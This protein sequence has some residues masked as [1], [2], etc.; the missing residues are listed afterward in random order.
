MVRKIRNVMPA[1]TPGSTP[2]RGRVFFAITLSFPFLILVLL[3]AVLRLVQYGGDLSLVVAKNVRGKEMYTINRAVARRYFIEGK[4]TVPEP[5]GGAFSIKKGD[6][7]KRIFCLGESTMAGFPYEFNATP[8]SFLSDYLHA[9]LPSYNFE[10]INVGLSAVGSAVVD[11]FIRELTAYEPDLF[12]V[13]VGHN[14][15]YGAYGAG[16]AVSAGGRPWMTDLTIHLLKF[17]TFLLLR[18]AYAGIGRL[19]GGPS[20]PRDATLMEQV[21]R[22]QIIPLGSDTYR[23]GLETYQKNLRSIIER[24]HSAGVPILFS[25]LVSN[26]RDQ[27]PFRSVLPDGTTGD[28][29]SAWESDLSAGD[30]LLASGQIDSALQMYEAAQTLAPGAA[31]STYRL[32]LALLRQGRDTEAGK[33]LRSAKDQDALR[34]RASEEFQDTL[35]AT[36][37]AFGVPVSRVDSAFIGASPHGLIGKELILEHLHPTVEGYLLMART[38]CSTLSQTGLL[39]PSPQWHWSGLPPDST[40]MDEAGVTEYDRITGDIRI[41]QLTHRWPFVEKTEPSAYLPS[42]PVQTQIADLIHRGVPWSDARYR[43]AEYYAS[44]HDFERARR[45]CRAVAHAIPYSYEPLLHIGDLYRREG[46]LDRAYETFEKSITTEDNPFARMNMAV[47][48]LERER[49]RDAVFQIETAFG[50]PAVK[51]PSFPRAATATGRYI[52][53]TAYARTGRFAEAREQLWQA[54]EAQPVYPEAREL[55]RRLAA[56]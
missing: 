23:T 14:E 36:C 38:W 55:L 24:A 32:G 44:Q 42:T 45:E 50:L 47:I 18:D 25:T 22:D 30:T 35:L 39:A 1:P 11:D 40:L 19:F 8:P 49:P 54:L 46:N 3:E 16:S 26:I 33:Q 34:F 56:R 2:T 41:V 17:K 31:R 13:Y 37:K 12:I 15:F 4:W 20:A 6:G 43:L 7:T 53:G 21:V 29:R 5:A 48:L 27:T 9:L 10:V 52:M 28:R 51:E